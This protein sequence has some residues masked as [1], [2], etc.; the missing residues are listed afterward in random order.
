MILTVISANGMAI[1]A[2]TS[3]R[4]PVLSLASGD[5][6]RHIRQIELYRMASLVCFKWMWGNPSDPNLPLHIRIDF[7]ELES[8]NSQSQPASHTDCFRLPLSRNSEAASLFTNITI[9]YSGR[10]PPALLWRIRE[11]MHCFT[12][13]R[14]ISTSPLWSPLSRNFVWKEWN[15]R[16]RKKRTEIGWHGRTEEGSGNLW[17]TIYV[18][19]R[20]SFLKVKVRVSRHNPQF[21]TKISQSIGSQLL[22]CSA[23]SQELAGRGTDGRLCEL[24]GKRRH[25]DAFEWYQAENNSE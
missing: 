5:G 17:Q 3:R 9:W 10:A 7:A 11:I 25:K 16:M 18:L 14:K 4:H 23:I 24:S 22:A 12:S 1:F 21:G 20:P 19:A 6:P 15:V 13:L 8:Q 2:C